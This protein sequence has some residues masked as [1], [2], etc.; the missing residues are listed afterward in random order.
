MAYMTLVKS[1]KPNT[2]GKTF[3]LNAEGKMTKHAIANVWHGE[4]QAHDVVTTKEFADLL[5][6][7]CEVSDIALMSGRFVGAEPKETV[8]LVTERKLAQLLNCELKNVPGGVQ[9]VGEK[10]YAARLKR[11]IEHS[12]WVLIDAD[13]PVGIPTEWAAMGIQQRLEILEPLVPGISA[14]T[15]VEYRSSSARVVKDGD[16][17]GGATHAWIQISDAT[18]LE[19]LREH[20]KVEMQLKGLSF[21]SPRHDKETGSVIGSEARTVM[22]LAV[23][24][25][26]RLVFCSKPE[27]RSEGYYVADA[28]V[29]IVNPDGGLLDV[30]RIA[31]PKKTTLEKLHQKTGQNLSYSR[32][33][34]GLTVKDRSSLNWETSIEVKGVTRSLREVVADLAPGD[35]LRCETPFRASQSEAAFIRILD[36]GMPMLHDVGTGTNYFLADNVDAVADATAPGSAVTLTQRFARMMANFPGGGGPASSVSG[37]T[38]TASVKELLKDKTRLVRS[39]SGPLQNYA[40]ALD[41]IRDTLEWHGVLAYNEMS[42]EI[43]LTL[44]IPGSFTPKS[45]FKVRSMKDEDFVLATAWFNKH[46]F[47]TIGKQ[48]VVDAVETVASENVI[49][50]IRHYLEDVEKQYGWEPGKHPSRLDRLFE[51]YFGVAP[52]AVDPGADPAYLALIGRKFMVSAVAR[53]LKPGCKVDTMLVLEGPQGAKK[54]SAARILSGSSYFS[55]NLPLM[56]TKDAS[57]HIRGK[58]IIEVGELSA[59]QKSDVEAIKAFVS[60]QEEKFRPAYARKTITYPRRCIFIG[61]TNQDAYLRDETGNRRFWPVKVGD[62]DLVALER[63][64]DL[65]WAEAVYWFRNG[66]KWYLETH[67]EALAKKVQNDRVSVDV[68]Q[69][70]LAEKLQDTTEVSIKEAA[71]LIGLDIARINGAEQNRIVVCLKANGFKRSGVFSSG[72]LRNSARYAKDVK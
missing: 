43:V 4:T 36:D 47:P 16:Q 7:V 61:T 23:W 35:K 8:N 52:N 48:I 46:G 66:E 68:W 10:K 62:V 6:Q 49:S 40:N 51:V 31:L 45:T 59:M 27:V 57:D 70:Q 13:N 56:G 17:P 60:R 42:E 2:L 38:S 50:P 5:M 65:L 64:R 15:R 9:I 20:V 63:D 3:E 1:T 37:Q 11:G 55:D 21:T 32:E 19:T 53:A 24:V 30:S 44:P 69:E 25:P 71:G 72:P 39:K 14:C 12:T 34:T 67:E 26:G 54:S 58:W 33:G 29:S 28:G 18:K 41:V 22:D